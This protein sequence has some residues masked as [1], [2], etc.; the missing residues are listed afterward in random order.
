[1]SE[2]LDADVFRRVLSDLQVGVYFT[3]RERRIV[4][5][6]SGAERITGY[7]SQEVIG[8]CCRENILMHCDQQR[9]MVCA[10]GCPLAEAIADGKPRE[11]SL[12]LQHKAGHRI[13]IRM[14]TIPIRG[15]T[16]AIIGAAECFQRQRYLPHP[17]RREAGVAG[18]YL[19]GGIP[20][21]GYMMSEL[22][23]RLARMAEGSPAFGVLCAKVDRLEEL[24]ERYGHEACETV[25]HVIA[26]TLQN[27]IRSSDCLG[28]W[29]EGRLLVVLASGAME[30]LI[31]VGERL[32]SLASCS[33]VVWW[34]DPVAV[35]ISS[36]ATVVKTDDTL[37]TLIARCERALEESMAG[38]GD[39]MTLLKE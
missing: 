13:P 14:H 35:T 12:F 8:R 1:M 36:G 2:I 31:R 18:S 7:L 34:G 6:N 5:W 24:R 15:A 25:L 32:R 16:G 4:F 21:Y 10:V 28:S 19:V 20:E 27:T 37:K 11:A 29:S 22:R 9:R 23:I 30:H 39:R 33:N 38:G 3:D 17:E 26:E